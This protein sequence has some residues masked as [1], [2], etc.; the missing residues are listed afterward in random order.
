MKF[1]RPALAVGL[2]MMRSAE[3]AAQ[4]SNLVVG[5]WPMIRNPH[6]RVGGGFHG[7]IMQR[8]YAAKKPFLFSGLILLCMMLADASRRLKR[9]RAHVRSHTL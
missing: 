6:M 9:I 3:H 2:S 1:E 7:V 8:I 4:T 5:F